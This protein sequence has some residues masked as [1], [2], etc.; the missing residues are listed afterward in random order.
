M[1]LRGVPIFHNEAMQKLYLK[2]FVIQKMEVSCALLTDKYHIQNWEMFLQKN[3]QNYK[4]IVILQEINDLINYAI[5]Q[6]LMMQVWATDDLL[7][8]WTIC[9]LLTGGLRKWYKPNCTSA[10]PVILILVRSCK[11]QFDWKKN[12]GKRVVFC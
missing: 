5:D 4:W 12:K 11:I 9:F 3:H 10:S 2:L 6:V 7:E 1:K 8:S